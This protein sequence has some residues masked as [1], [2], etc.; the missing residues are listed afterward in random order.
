MLDFDLAEL[1]E[2]ATKRLNEQVE[3]NID[4]FPVDFAFVLNPQEVSNLKSQIA[5]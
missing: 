4:R 1:Y 5:T 3:R 2:V